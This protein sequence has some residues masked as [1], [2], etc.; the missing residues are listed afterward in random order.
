MEKEK[1]ENRLNLKIELKD[2]DPGALFIAKR[3]NDSGYEALVVGGCIRN[4]VMGEEVH[5]WDI[6]TKATPEEISRAFKEFKVIP[7]GK[8][9][10][11]VTIVTNHINYEVSTFKKNKSVPNPNLLEDLRHRDFTVNALAWREGEGVI[12]YFNGLEDIKQKIIGGVEDP[13]ERI[14]E[15]PLRMLRAI[16]LACELDFKIDK[17]TLRA[18]EKNVLLIKKVSVERI[19]DE[20]T[21]ILLSNDSRRGF[22]LLYRLGLLIF[23]MPE[24]QKCAGIYKENFCE[25]GDFLEHTLDMTINLPPDLNLRLSGLLYNIKSISRINGR[26]E[27]MVKIL[28]R[29][30]FNNTVIKKVIV[31]TK[32]NWQILNFSKKINIRQ[33]ASR[34]GMENLEDAWELKKAFIKGSRSSESFKSAEI[35]RAENN[36]K[37]TLQERPPVS[38][39]DLTV[40]GKDL[41]ELGYNEGKEIKDILNRF[42]NLVLEKPALNQKEK[43]LEMIQAIGN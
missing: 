30:R 19:R 9:F 5:D 31:L 1:K 4:L 6:T 3:L 37:E 36:L 13:V 15:D 32:E 7:V 28:K 20:F 35:E 39:K 29:M 34:I 23:I 27:I 33:L 8:K 16:R 14:K 24:L 41:I 22:R 2:I 42:L 21:K 38:L 10:G 11:T 26:K 40:K 25:G 17:A 12:D 18:I 43:L